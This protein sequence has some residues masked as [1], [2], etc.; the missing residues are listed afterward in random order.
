MIKLKDILNMVTDDEPVN[1]SVLKT[2]NA[3]DGSRIYHTRDI[4]RWCTKRECFRT[5]SEEEMNM[6]ISR[7]F[8][9][10]S[11]KVY[12]ITLIKEEN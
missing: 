1:V 4:C 8:Y 5:L 2:E 11:L 7:V 10:Q 9:H 12:S 3:E 6:S